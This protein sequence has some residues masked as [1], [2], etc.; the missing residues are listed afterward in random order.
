LLKKDMCLSPSP[1]KNMMVSR[2]QRS[3]GST[4]K[5]QRAFV[6]GLLSLCGICPASW[7]EDYLYTVKPG[8]NPWSI[9]SQ[10][11]IDMSYW[12]RLQSYNQLRDSRRIPPGTTLRIPPAW[13]RVS[14]AGITLS[15]LHGLVEVNTGKGWSGVD[16]PSDEPPKLRLAT[17]A[18]LRTGANA[19][20]VLTLDNGAKVMV[21]P[22][23]EI[24]VRQLSSSAA[25]GYVVQIELLRGGLENAV[26]PL[27]ETGG[28]M[29]IVTPAAT[30]AVRGT[31][32]RV[33]V[34]DDGARTEVLDGAVD[35]LNPHGTVGLKD[36]QG[37]VARVGEIPLPASALLGAPDLHELPAV[38][39]RL[40]WRQGIAALPGATSYRIQILQAPAQQTDTPRPAA[41]PTLLVEHRA[42]QAELPAAIGDGKYLLRVRAIDAQGLEG[43]TAEKAF[44]LDTQP[45]APA[46]SWPPENAWMLAGTPQFRWSA[47]DLSGSLYAG[48][49]VLYHLQISD[50]PGFASIKQEQLTSML[51]WQAQRLP[52][53]NYFWRIASV[54]A[55][56]HGPFSEAHVLNVP[57]GWPELGA[58]SVDEQLTVRWSTPT[59]SPTAPVEPVRLQ[60]ASDAAFQRVLFDEPTAGG[61]IALPRPG[62]GR[63][64]LRIAPLG[65]ADE[66][67]VWSASREIQVGH[68]R[69]PSLSPLYWISKLGF[70]PS[71]P[72]STTR[73]AP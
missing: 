51:E 22:S 36:R 66:T 29:E 4:P 32:F 54:V 64:Y 44:E 57:A 14:G 19:S 7:A 73:P 68:S 2:E 35:V 53:G 17:G 39:D 20:A 25:S 26:H 46:P 43:L 11:L 60:I 47:A 56:D 69:W 1:F 40:P 52:A 58:I 30:T 8:D 12:P 24:L 21:R 45:P 16:A 5:F 3:A 55:S 48:E 61:T 65:D 71:R 33:S 70:A 31:T 34:S 49:T 42:S 13:L 72:G 27:R 15:A 63:Y 9:S 41:D 6:V 59:R 10:Y 67:V 62:A 37:S 50:D 23:S 18:R 28:R 38:V